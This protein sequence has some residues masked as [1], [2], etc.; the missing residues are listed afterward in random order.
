MRSKP[1]RKG[2]VR[3][4]A[5]GE[6]A[7]YLYG[8][9][10]GPVEEPLG[11]SGIG[12]SSG[13]VFVIPY[14]DIAAAVSKTP[15]TEFP[16]SRQNVLAHQRVLLSLMERYTV[17]PIS[18]GN[19]LGTTHDVIEVL[20]GG[21]DGFKGTLGY[22]HGKIEVGLAVSWKPEAFMEELK[23]IGKGLTSSIGPRRRT[24]RQP[25]HS[26]Q[27]AI[28]TGEAAAEA[29]TARAAKIGRTIHDNL[30]TCTVSSRLNAPL[31]E[32][33]VLNAAYLVEKARETEFDQRVNEVAAEIG[34]RFDFNYT[35]PWPPY[36]FVD[37]KL[38]VAGPGQTSGR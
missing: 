11:L 25:S 15:E 32:R 18:F 19:T 37:I 10:G 34:D 30:K 4:H 35:G 28:S 7:L 5:S 20:R 36:N 16:P 24:L 6:G 2:R 14:G 3:G 8:I 12:P 21:Y 27:T 13:E 26:L 33:M 1:P 9:V 29:L 38:R 31:G 23:S 17:I 22:V